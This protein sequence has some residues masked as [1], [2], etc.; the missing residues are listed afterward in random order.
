MVFITHAQVALQLITTTLFFSRLPKVRN[1]LATKYYTT[2]KV[3][4]W[5]Q[6]SCHWHL[7]LSESITS[8]DRIGVRSWELSCWA[9]AIISGLIHSSPILYRACDQGT[10]LQSEAQVALKSCY[11]N[12]CTTHL[13]AYTYLTQNGSAVLPV[14]HAP[15]VLIKTVIIVS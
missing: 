4:L 3:E 12:A 14:F 1:I 10:Q 11:R 6:T 15:A 8:V 9:G 2:F 5:L 7:D 13:L